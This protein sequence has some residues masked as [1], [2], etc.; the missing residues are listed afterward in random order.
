MESRFSFGLVCCLVVCFFPARQQKKDLHVSLQSRLALTLFCPVIPRQNQL[1]RS[2]SVI[3]NGNLQK[4]ATGSLQE[5][6]STELQ[7]PKTSPEVGSEGRCWQPT[8][9]ARMFNQRKCSWDVPGAGSVVSHT[10][11]FSRTEHVSFTKQ[12]EIP[13]VSSSSSF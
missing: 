3:I 6:S 9:P 2:L 12:M 4:M 13:H 5:Y 7:L 1:H 8:S 11:G 10:W